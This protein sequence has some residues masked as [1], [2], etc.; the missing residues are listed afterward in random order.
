MRDVARLVTLVERDDPAAAAERAAPLAAIEDRPGRAGRR[1]HRRARRRQVDAARRAHLHA[2][3]RPRRAASRSSRSTRRAPPRAAPC[4]AT[5]RGSACRGP[6]VHPLA[7]LAGGVAGGLAPSTYPVVRALR[8]LFDLV[9][10]ETVGV[11]QS[12]DDV[13]PRRRR[14][15]PAAAAARRR[16][17][18][19]LKAGL[20]EAPDA[21]VVTKCDVGRRWR[22]RALADL[23]RRDRARPA[24][25]RRLPL[26]AVSARTGAGID[27]LAAAVAATV[28]AR[29]ERAARR[30]VRDPRRPHRPRPARCRAPGRARAPGVRVRW[31]SAWPRRSPEPPLRPP[32]P[33]AS[34]EPSR[35]RRCAAPAYPTVQGR[36]ASSR[37]P[38]IYVVEHTRHRFRS[39]HGVSLNRR[40]VRFRAIR[41][42]LMR[43]Q[44]PKRPFGV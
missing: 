16:Q 36:D 1:V 20:M 23:R 9:L 39:P 35:P 5:A 33:A 34:G 27:D 3:A 12:E 21:I 15:L 44:T 24:R 18:Q 14:H 37:A 42:R 13:A 17:L 25:A 11:G 2:R 4:S 26:H 19:H 38:P 6:R 31:T 29:P 28:P 40:R 22:S 32:E 43:G 30:L 8:R 7:G 41:A 10:V